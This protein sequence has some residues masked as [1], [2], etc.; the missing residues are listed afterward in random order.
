[1]ETQV[2]LIYSAFGQKKKLIII[3][4]IPATPPAHLSV[5]SPGALIVFPA[6]GLSSW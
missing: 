5:K 4:A 3:Y 6:K 2:S 1:M